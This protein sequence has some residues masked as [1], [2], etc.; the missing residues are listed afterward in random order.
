LAPPGTTIE[1]EHRD[2]AHEGIRAAQVSLLAATAIG[3]AFVAG[4]ADADV[5]TL[6]ELASTDRSVLVEASTAVLALE[7]AAK[8]TRVL[9]SQLLRQAARRL[10]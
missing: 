4:D 7:V 8:R 3:L 2:H 6:V 5:A 10:A 1:P 9:A